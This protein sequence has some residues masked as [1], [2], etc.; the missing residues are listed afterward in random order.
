MQK[1]RKTQA[2]RRAGTI[3]KV[4]D[5]ASDALVESGY[6]GTSMQLVATRAGV[7]I[8]GLFRH[9]P[10]REALMVA[11]GQDAGRQILAKY[12]NAF[13]S[14]HG[15]EEP[16]VLALRLLRDTCRSRINQ[17]WLELVHAC[18][19]DPALRKALAPV[20]KTYAAQIEELA[21]ALLPDLA[22]ALGGRF[23]LFV[24]TMV[25]VFDGEQMH[26][27]LYSDKDL[28]A[29]RIDALAAAAHALVR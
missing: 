22:A 25:A 26:R 24:D 14:L 21:R 1:P 7:S 28:E 29:A 27:M 10:T 19:T 9:F 4:L 17:V 15:A 23:A 12:T 5:A 3:R 18:R 2:E 13:E 6:A 11:V 16:I 20:G 8:G